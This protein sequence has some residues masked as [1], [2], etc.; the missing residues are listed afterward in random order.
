MYK[1]LHTVLGASGAIGRAVIRELQIKQLPTRSVGRSAKIKGIEN[2]Q[3]DLFS[4]TEAKQAIQGSTHVY[5]CIGLPYR[6]D[7]WLKDWPL[8]MQNV[9]DACAANNAN[10]I[11]F[12]NV[13]M[14]GPPPLVFLLMKIIPKILLH[15]KE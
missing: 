11:F 7:V 9:I 4:N 8:L 3:A 12:D 6:S 13:Y 1:Q 5:L 14:Y 15:K 10:L 2:I